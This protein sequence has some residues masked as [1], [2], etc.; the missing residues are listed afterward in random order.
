MRRLTPAE[1]ALWVQWLPYARKI[2][3]EF[4]A[5]NPGL[6]NLRDEVQAA[7][8]G[9]GGEAILHWDASRGTYASCLKW[10]V[11]SAIQDVLAARL[12]KAETLS[13][14]G[15][16]L[17]GSVAERRQVETLGDTVPDD[18]L[19]APDAC[20]DAHALS[21]RALKELP[22][23]MVGRRTT[24][25]AAQQAEM[26]VRLWYSRTTDG[27]VTFDEIGTLVGSQRQAVQQRVARVQKAFEKWARTIRE[28]AV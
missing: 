17:L 6:A 16:S 15:P 11:W 12:P 9:A 27:E 5:R 23:H 25:L 22:R 7:A 24:R 10:W 2:A 3:R 26:S 8:E 13:L 14:D 1:Q 21:R 18:S 19:P 28:E 20:I 4:I